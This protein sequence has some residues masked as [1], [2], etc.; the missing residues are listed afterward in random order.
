MSFPAP[1]VIVLAPSPALIVL[2]IPANPPV[3]M[4]S[5]PEPVVIVFIPGNSFYPCRRSNCIRAVASID[6]V[7][8]GRH[9]NRISTTTR[10]NC[11]AA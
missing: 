5:A 6:R 1:V 4:V 7:V 9:S 2:P 8:A 10:D 3:V 11:V